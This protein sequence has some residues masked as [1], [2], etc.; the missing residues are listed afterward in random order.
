MKDLPLVEMLTDPS[1]AG[2]ILVTTYPLAGNYGINKH[3]F[4]SNK[5]QVSGFVVRGECPEPSHY[6]SRQTL[7]Q[8]LAE[9]GIPGIYGV[10]TRAIT[11]R[12]RSNGVMMGVITS[13]QS[14]QQALRQIREGSR[15]G[16]IDFVRQVTSDAI[17]QWERDRGSLYHCR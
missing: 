9:N 8:Y 15:Y 17:Y 1:Y 12:L 3:D 4:E 11:R 2:Q 5:I 10:D 16:S 14:P 13:E 7:H 6:L